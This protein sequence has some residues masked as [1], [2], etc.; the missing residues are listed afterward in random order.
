MRTNCAVFYF[1]IKRTGFKIV[2]MCLWRDGEPAEIVAYRV[3]ERALK[4]RDNVK[5]RDLEVLHD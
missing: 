3:I 5:T 4:Y 1:R 2:T